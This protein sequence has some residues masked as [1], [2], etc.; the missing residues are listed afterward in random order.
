[1]VT[2][3]T[4]VPP[5]KGIGRE[6]LDALCPALCERQLGGREVQASPPRPM[7]SAR[8]ADQLDGSR[9]IVPGGTYTVPRPGF[10][11]LNGGAKSLP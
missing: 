9:N 8:F 1:M 10:G 11:S 5:I 3:S 4:L 6:T 2:F 7:W